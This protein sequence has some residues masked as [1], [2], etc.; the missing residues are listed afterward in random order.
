MDA[1]L[2]DCAQLSKHVDIAVVFMWPS[3]IY[4]PRQQ[5]ITFVNDP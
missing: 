1:L 3:V 2:F 5:E 4:I